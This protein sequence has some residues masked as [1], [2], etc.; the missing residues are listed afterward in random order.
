MEEFIGAIGLFAFGL[1]PKGWMECDG[2]LLAVTQYQAL[3]SLLGV[4]YGGD[5][6][7]TFGIPDL[8]GRAIVGASP[9]YLAGTK[10]G[11]ESATLATGQMPTHY[12]SVA[13]STVV[14]NSITADGAV[15]A[16]S[17]TTANLPTPPAIYAPTGTLVEM[18]SSSI[19]TTGGNVPHNNMQPF[20]VL[21]YCICVVGHFPSRN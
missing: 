3:F 9:A 14:G 19:G 11:V 6:K 5:G 16:A 1:V 7:T 21:N 18:G 15:I 20:Q 10:G 2:R 17:A 4:Q 8:R 12:H 13:V